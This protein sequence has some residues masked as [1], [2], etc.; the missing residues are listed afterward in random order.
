M[1]SFV[2]IGSNS[3]RAED[4]ARST[5]YQALATDKNSPKNYDTTKLVKSWH[6]RVP[7]AVKLLTI[8]VNSISTALPIGLPPKGGQVLPHF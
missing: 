6:S 8:L 2:K 7:I 3:G 1:T 4:L 5:S